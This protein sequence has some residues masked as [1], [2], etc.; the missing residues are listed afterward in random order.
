MVR[1]N[2]NEVV[3]A[4]RYIGTEDKPCPFCGSKQ[5]SIEEWMGITNFVCDECGL[6]VSFIG[7]ESEEAA[8]ESW[9]R[10]EL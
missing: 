5:V 6:I 2:E 4:V 7:K 8:I 10:R 9:N 3:D 1:R